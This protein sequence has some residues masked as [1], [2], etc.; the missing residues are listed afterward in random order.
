MI[1]NGDYGGDLACNYS[2]AV[3]FNS[4]QVDAISFPFPDISRFISFPS[5]SAKPIPIPGREQFAEG[6]SVKV[7]PP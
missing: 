4:H 3:T 2:S 5:R 1:F 7:K 6:R